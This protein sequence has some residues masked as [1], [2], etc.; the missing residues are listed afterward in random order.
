M[1]LVRNL[2]TSA[3]LVNGASGVVTEFVP[4]RW[5]PA[6]PRVEF[7]AVEGINDGRSVS[8]VIGSEEFSI[9]VGER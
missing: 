3:G 2:D 1:L 5:G 6:L 8:R 7:E 4:Q 9:N